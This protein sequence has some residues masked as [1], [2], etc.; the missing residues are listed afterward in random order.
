MSCLVFLY[1]L[2]TTAAAGI[3][4]HSSGVRI[5]QISL[6]FVFFECAKRSSVVHHFRLHTFLGASG[7]SEPVLSSCTEAPLVVCPPG[8]HRR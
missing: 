6:S 7:V 4:R 2:F 3:L 5:W 1:Q 8:D